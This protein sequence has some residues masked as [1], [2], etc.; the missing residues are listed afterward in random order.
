M[1]WRTLRRFCLAALMLLTNPVT[2]RAAEDTA[3]EPCSVYVDEQ[4]AMDEVERA[5]R[6]LE[7]A[8]QSLKRQKDASLAA[9]AELVKSPTNENAQKT[10]AVAAA[11]GDAQRKVYDA[12]QALEAQERQV[13]CALKQ[14]SWHSTLGLAI[15]GAGGAGGAARW[16]V[17]VHVGLKNTPYSQH[18]LE[19]NY[20]QLTHFDFDPVAY[21][22]M[23]DKEPFASI[24]Y[25]YAFR[26]LHLS[27]GLASRLSDVD[28]ANERVWITGRTAVEFGIWTPDACTTACFMTNA[29]LFVEPWIPLD[30]ETPVTIVGGVRIQL[31]VGAG[32]IVEISKSKEDTKSGKTE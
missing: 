1:T 25:S 22:R 5:D 10:K 27:F 29:S 3:P 19:V 9:A 12:K 2:A 7:E 21:R 30:G 31:G 16:G 24:L 26:R 23:G 11:L 14:K 17:G 8:Y 15:H 4:A 32:P 20:L 28:E 6:N 18:R 13:A